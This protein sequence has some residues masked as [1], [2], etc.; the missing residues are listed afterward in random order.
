MLT[1][2]RLQDKGKVRQLGTVFCFE[3]SHRAE[4]GSDILTK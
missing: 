1:G 4:T 2:F 3:S